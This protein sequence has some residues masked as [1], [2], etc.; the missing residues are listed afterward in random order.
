MQR[1]DS[2]PEVGGHAVEGADPAGEQRGNRIR[3][4]LLRPQRRGDTRPEPVGAVLV[5]DQ[6][7]RAGP[8]RRLTRLG[9]VGDV[10][11]LHPV[12]PG[13]KRAE[14]ADEPALVVCGDVLTAHKEQVVLAEEAAQLRLL[15]GIDKTL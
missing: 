10:R 3:R 4:D 2:R 13:V 6:L 5:P 14:I 15:F 1:L 11:L 8:G 7:G 9:E 12:R